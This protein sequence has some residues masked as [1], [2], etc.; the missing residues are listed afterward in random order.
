MKITEKWLIDNEACADG[1]DFVKR[2]K[3]IGFPVELLG[4]IEGDYNEYI[5]WVVDSLKNE[6]VYDDNNN[7]V[8]IKTV[9]G[10]TV[11]K[12]YDLRNNIIYTRRY[13]E[14]NPTKNNIEN[15]FVYDDRDN[16]ILHKDNDGYL[17]I[18]EYN[19]RN[20]RIS[21]QDGV[22][23][24]RTFSYDD[25]DNL[26]L[27][28]MNGNIIQQC[29]YDDRNNCIHS[30]YEKAEHWYSYDENNNRIYKKTSMGFE[31]HYSFD[32]NHNVIEMTTIIKNKY[33]STKETKNKIHDKCEL[34]HDGQLKQYNELYIP[35]FEK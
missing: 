1:I 15:W 17:I 29:E 13:A 7:V 5:T 26:I 11:L 27:V 22:Y 3:L 18:Y 14:K 16:V 4:D 34:Y 20:K 28:M 23:S 35:Y 8:K 25:N 9:D 32:E 12:T 21:A 2:N 10:F 30:K 31:Y 6:I 19:E 24:K 33:D